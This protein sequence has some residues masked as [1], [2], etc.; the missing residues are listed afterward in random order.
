MAGPTGLQGLTGL[1]PATGQP[2]YYTEGWVDPYEQIKGPDPVHGQYT[3]GS[4]PAF[5]WLM[6]QEQ[7]YGVPPLPDMPIGRIP[8]ASLPVESD[9]DLYA[10]PTETHSHTAPW[11]TF[12]V[13]D[14]SPH[15]A[16]HQAWR[17]EANAALHSADTGQAAAFT[18]RGDLTT[19]W[20]RDDMDYV[21]AGE[22]NLQPVPDQLRGNLGRD[23]VQGYAPVNVDGFDSAHVHVPGAET[24]VAGNYLWLTPTSRPV[25]VRPTGYRDWPVGP[26]S[27]FEGQVPGSGGLGDPTAAVITDPPPS[28]S[29]PPEPAVAAPLTGDDTVWA[30]W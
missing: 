23:R 5:P 29:P 24:D 4:P 17:I 15:D 27:P 11:P 12:G 25:V 13:D 22:T 9:P 14:F 21:S 16:S 19:P 26:D 28:Y 7:G 3:V 6:I 10:S 18:M 8:H 20:L 1:A 2:D 30:R